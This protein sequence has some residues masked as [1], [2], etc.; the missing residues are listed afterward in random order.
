MIIVT[1]NEAPATHTAADYE[2]LDSVAVARAE[3]AFRQRSHT[4]DDYLSPREVS[5][6]LNDM[7][8]MRKKQIH[9]VCSC[10]GI[11]LLYVSL[12]LVH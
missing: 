4:V 6:E 12:E 2:S 1:A 7:P 10:V 9:T 8:P 5:P 3:N 11:L